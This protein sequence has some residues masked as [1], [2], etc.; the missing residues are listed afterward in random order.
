MPEWTNSAQVMTRCISRTNHLVPPL[1]EL[2]RKL[3]I[4]EK[5]TRMERKT[6]LED[7]ATSNECTLKNKSSTAAP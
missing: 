7:E 1:I 5:E 4:K 6:T 3:Q 2:K